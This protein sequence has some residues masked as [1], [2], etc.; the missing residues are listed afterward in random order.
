MT[1]PKATAELV[2]ALAPRVVTLPSGH[3]LM[4]E[5]PDA[6]LDALREVLQAGA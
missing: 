4:G 1:P 3:A 5:A 2:K 6:L